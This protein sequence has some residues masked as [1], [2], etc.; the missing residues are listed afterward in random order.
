MRRRSEEL[1]RGVDR[2]MQFVRAVDSA[3]SRAAAGA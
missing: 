3:R 2:I 1:K